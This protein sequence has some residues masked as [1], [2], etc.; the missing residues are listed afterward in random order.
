MSR[1]KQV[2]LLLQMGHSEHNRWFER[3]IHADLAALCVTL[4]GAG[5]I[6]VLDLQTQAEA[7]DDQAP[8][9]SVDGAVEAA[10][11]QG[12]S[13]QHVHSPF[14]IYDSAHG[15]RVWRVVGE[16]TAVID[17]QT[18]ELLEITFN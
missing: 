13:S 18:G 7:S 17:A 2:T 16:D 1:P 6:A 12:A 3:R 4:I 14:P 8:V 9:I 5:A 10:Q 11:A 15:A